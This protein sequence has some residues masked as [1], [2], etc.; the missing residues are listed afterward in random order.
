MS[1]ERHRPKSRRRMANLSA[2]RTTRKVVY[3]TS[4]YERGF[5][6]SVSCSQIVDSPDEVGSDCTELRFVSKDVERQTRPSVVF[7]H[8]KVEESVF[9]GGFQRA[10]G[11]AP[12]A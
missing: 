9:H 5:R 11:F 2:T 12:K 6:E 10:Q 1:V 3:V 7:D 8:G 4:P